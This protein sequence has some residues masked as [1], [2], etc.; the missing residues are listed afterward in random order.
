VEFSQPKAVEVAE[1]PMP[2]LPLPKQAPIV[3]A[4]AAAQPTKDLAPVAKRLSPPPQQAAVQPTRTLV[5]KN[6]PHNLSGSELLKSLF[7][8]ASNISVQGGKGRAFVDFKTAEDATAAMAECGGAEVGGRAMR[9]VYCK[10]RAPDQVRAIPV[11][12]NPKMAAK[13][14]ASLT[15][16]PSARAREVDALR[17][18]GHTVSASGMRKFDES[19]LV[20]SA[21]IGAGFGA[22]FG[23]SVSINTSAHTAPISVVPVGTS[24]GAPQTVATPSRPSAPPSSS[25]GM[26]ALRQ[27]MIWSQQKVRM[28]H[29]TCTPLQ[30]RNIIHPP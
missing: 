14:E 20:Q 3:V 5:A 13:A 18:A 25:K 8:A 19:M 4:E 17:A 15:T 16:E 27:H 29:P 11:V 1:A 10:P 9:L 21:R 12:A 22:G 7:P 6:L 23:A 30:L 2:S 24:S 28:R 26:A